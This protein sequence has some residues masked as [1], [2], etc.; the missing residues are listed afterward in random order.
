M[1]RLCKNQP[2]S[3]SLYL[4][5]LSLFD[6]ARAKPTHTRTPR[7]AHTHTLSLPSRQVAPVVHAQSAHWLPL[8]LHPRRP[9]PPPPSFHPPPPPPPSV[10][11]SNNSHDRCC[12]SIFL[13][14]LLQR[15]SELPLGTYGSGSGSGCVRAGVKSASIELCVGRSDEGIDAH[16]GTSATSELSLSLSLTH[17]HT[18]SHTLTHTC[19]L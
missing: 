5:S 17:T 16:S 19:S 14:A 3:L 7:G 4:P 18:H 11:S 13:F 12:W 10:L 9:N 6:M 2:H 15:V 1:Q 8:H